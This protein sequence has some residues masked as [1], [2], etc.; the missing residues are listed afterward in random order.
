MTPD[1]LGVLSEEQVA[2][3]KNLLLKRQL[4]L[5]DL[6]QQREQTSRPVELDQQSVGRVSR[7]DAIQQQQMAAANKKQAEVE[8]KQIFRALKEIEEEEYGYCQECDKPIPFARL[9]I[10]P[11]AALCI[12]C[13]QFVER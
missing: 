3:I 4:E 11:T 13:Q 8:L 5:Q 6:L 12:S 2:E 9:Q 1:S 10:K 7:I